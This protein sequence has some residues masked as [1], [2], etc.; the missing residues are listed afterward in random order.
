MTGPSNRVDGPGLLPLEDAA[1]AAALESAILAGAIPELFLWNKRGDAYMLLSLQGE[2][3]S[4][5]VRLNEDGPAGPQAAPDPG[6][7][8]GSPRPS[9]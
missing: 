2:G 5:L 8:P 7:R 3:R 4:T 9:V 6:D 1:G